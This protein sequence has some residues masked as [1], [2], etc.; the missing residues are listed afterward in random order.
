MSFL[1]QKQGDLMILSI[2]P[3][4]F[5]TESNTDGVVKAFF[6]LDTLEATIYS[7]PPHHL[8]LARI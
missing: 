7:L 2:A 4:E 8:Y 6:V 3:L 5:Q 1:I